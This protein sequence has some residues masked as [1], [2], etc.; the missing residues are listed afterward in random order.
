VLSRI[1]RLRDD[2][3]GFTLVELLMSIVI[4]GIIA[5]PLGE[6]IIGYLKNADATVARMSESHD[7]QIAAAYFAQDVQAVG[8]RDYTVTTSGFF[9]L[10][11]SVWTDVAPTAGP[12]PCGAAGLPNAVVRLAWDDFPSGAA[13]PADQVRAAYVVENG[14]EL[15]R[16]VCK[17]SAVPVSDVVVAHH[18]I[19]VP[20]VA[21]TGT[22]ADCNGSGTAVP[23]TVTLTL[24]IH[25]PQAPPGT[26]YTVDLTGQRRQ[27]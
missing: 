20:T 13:S 25:D 10:A 1:R 2:E 23:A 14:T 16:L 17:G 19:S 24:T 11:Q 22:T 5:V 4:L 27:S 8:V 9:P 12:F 7:A 15:H 26:Q 6:V 21:C 18:L 3:S